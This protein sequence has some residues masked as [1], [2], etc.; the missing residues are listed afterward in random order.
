LSTF[1][2]LS[3]ALSFVIGLGVTYLLSSL[4]SLFRERRTC[5]PDWLALLW[6]GYI[7]TYQV[8]FWW[9]LFEISAMEMWTLPQY[10]GLLSFSLLLFGAG[11]LVIPHDAARHPEGLRAYF[12][13]DGRWGVGLLSTYFVLAPPLNLW[14]FGTPVLDP[15]NVSIFAMGLFGLGFLRL[16]DRRSQ[17]VH[18]VVFGIVAA[19]L[20]VWMSPWSY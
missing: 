16:A 15:L 19:G 8:Q 1:E 18:S 13:T 20:F 17:V 9:A 11:G 5:R 10:L 4:L 12:E 6:A 14:F 3:I 7:F 2:Y